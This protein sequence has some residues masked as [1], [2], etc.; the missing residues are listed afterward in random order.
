MDG[1]GNDG[2]KEKVCHA[3]VSRRLEVSE[4][5]DIMRNHA[6]SCVRECEEKK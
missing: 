5:G 1:V 3:W 4:V 2:R 6:K